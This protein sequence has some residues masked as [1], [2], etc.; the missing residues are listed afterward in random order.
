MNQ[1]GPSWL[2]DFVEK[3]IRSRTQHCN[4][5][6]A[7]RGKPTN[8]I[9]PDNEHSSYLLCKHIVV[10]LVESVSMRNT[11]QNSDNNETIQHSETV[12]DTAKTKKGDNLLQVYDD[13]QCIDE[14]CTN[15]DESYD[16]WDMEGFNHQHSCDDYF[17]EGEMEVQGRHTMIESD[18]D[19]IQVM[20]DREVS[21]LEALSLIPDCYKRDKMTLTVPPLDLLPYRA[22]PKKKIYVIEIRRP[23]LF[24]P[25]LSPHKMLPQSSTVTVDEDIEIIEVIPASGDM[26]RNGSTIQQTKVSCCKLAPEAA[27]AELPLPLD[28]QYLLPPNAALDIPLVTT[29]TREIDDN[30]QIIGHHVPLSNPKFATGIAAASSAGPALCS[31]PATEYENNQNVSEI[32]EMRRRVYRKLIEKHP[33]TSYPCSSRGFY[34]DSDCLFGPAVQGPPPLQ[35]I[36]DNENRGHFNSNIEMFSSKSSSRCRYNKN[37]SVP[38]A[39]Y[40]E[41]GIDLGFRPQKQFPPIRG[42]NQR[43]PCDAEWFS[44]MLK[45]T[46]GGQGGVSHFNEDN[47]R[48]PPRKHQRLHNN[49]RKWRK[50]RHNGDD[51]YTSIQI[52]QSNGDAQN[53]GEVENIIQILHWLA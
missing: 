7:P 6:T 25:N 36:N 52:N 42:Q 14:E 32:A 18:D 53:L 43:L 24:R 13:M 9:D 10:S 45:E 33:E 28:L 49:R 3:E 31:R 35:I 29:K 11:M 37:S 26:E 8:A 44:A 17:I 5:G 48:S 19:D 21:R 15:Y 22:W 16:E 1:P 12:G 38:D 4:K 2:G 39:V 23:K 27:S 34:I 20:D 46:N 40:E 30:V 50:R 47:D 41:E 51:N